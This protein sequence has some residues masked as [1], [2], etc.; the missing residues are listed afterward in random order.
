MVVC[1]QVLKHT[2]V[3]V[4]CYYAC[5]DI[6]RSPECILAAA[7]HARL[8]EG[9]KKPLKVIAQDCRELAQEKVVGRPETPCS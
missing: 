6:L 1:G 4:P 9:K 7:G 3:A 2:A 5:S 8:A